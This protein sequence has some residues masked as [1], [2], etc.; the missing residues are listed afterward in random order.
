[1]CNAGGMPLLLTRGDF[2][3]VS[4]NKRT[5][6]LPFILDTINVSNKS[7]LGPCLLSHFITEPSYSCLSRNKLTGLLTIHWASERELGLIAVWPSVGEKP[8]AIQVTLC[9]P[10]LC[11]PPTS[12]NDL[13]TSSLLMFPWISIYLSQLPI[14][15]LSLKIAQLKSVL[16]AIS[17]FVQSEKLTTKSSLY[18]VHVSV[19][20][21]QTRQQ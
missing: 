16:V 15:V 2:L 17:C 12:S 1:M 3:V 6:N 4:C 11:P 19:R 7:N 8:T 14:S 9:S 18:Q 13:L 5:F 21:E 20:V 10:L